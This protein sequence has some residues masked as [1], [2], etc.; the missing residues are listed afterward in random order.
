MISDS[1]KMI[2][3]KHEGFTSLKQGFRHFSWFYD[4]ICRIGVDIQILK[5]FRKKLPYAYT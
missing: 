5:L 2:W 3:K 1:F 4:Q